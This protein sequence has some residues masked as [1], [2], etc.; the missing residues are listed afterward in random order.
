MKD[1]DLIPDPCTLHV[2][3]LEQENEPQMAPE[4]AVQC[5]NWGTHACDVKCGT[6]INSP[7]TI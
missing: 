4:A 2:S 3:V 1:A 5:V 7:F 6:C